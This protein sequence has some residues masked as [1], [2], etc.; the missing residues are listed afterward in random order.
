MTVET[1]I[2]E[3]EKAGNVLER[4]TLVYLRQQENLPRRLQELLLNYPDNLTKGSKVHETLYVKI[5]TP[6]DWQDVKKQVNRPRANTTSR[7]RPSPQVFGPQS[8]G[9]D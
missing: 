1:F 3:W 4:I 9:R 5:E 8:S 6:G 2:E 7:P